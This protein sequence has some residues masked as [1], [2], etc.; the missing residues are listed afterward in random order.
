VEDLVPF[1]IFIVIALINLVKF[2]MEK[3]AKGKPPASQGGA[4]P[5]RAPSSIEEFFEEIARK[6][7]PKPTPVP[8]WPQEIERPDYMKEMEEFQ[9]KQDDEDWYDKPMP[10][11]V[12]MPEP[13]PVP[14]LQSKPMPMVEP[15]KAIKASPGSIPNVFSSAKGMRISSSLMKTGSAVGTINFSIANKAQ[16][17]KAIIANIVLSRARAYDEN[18]E[19]TIVK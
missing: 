6:F 7:E 4:P 19:N 2:I 13:A 17:K 10:E 15:A 18:F 5:A 1:L 11:P 9:A 16:L 3:S 14:I 8:E 12:T